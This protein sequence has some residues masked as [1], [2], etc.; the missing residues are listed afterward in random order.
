MLER[1]L[2]ATF[3][4]SWLLMPL[5]GLAD[6]ATKFAARAELACRKQVGAAVAKFDSNNSFTFKEAVASAFADKKYQ[7][8]IM[9]GSEINAEVCNSLIGEKWG[10]IE[11]SSNTSKASI[12]INGDAKDYPINST[13]PFLVNLYS[14]KITKGRK[15]CYGDAQVLENQVKTFH[16]DF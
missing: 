6:D 15:S 10:R 14:V 1:L 11:F 7:R 2:L 16:C 13:Q 5:D 12:Y 9:A 8:A 4:I 3:C